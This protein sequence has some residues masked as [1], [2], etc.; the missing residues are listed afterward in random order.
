MDLSVGEQLALLSADLGDAVV[1]LAPLSDVRRADAEELDD[2]AALGFMGAHHADMPDAYDAASPVRQLPLDRPLLVIHGD[3]DIRAPETRSADFAVAAVATGD[4]V[5]P[6]VPGLS[7]MDQIDPVAP[8]WAGSVA[9]MEH[10]APA[11]Q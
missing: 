9:W 1:G 5:V 11:R 2:N 4:T 3:V 6:D 8:H 7:H 10:Q